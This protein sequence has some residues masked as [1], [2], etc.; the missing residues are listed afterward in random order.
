M[1]TSSMTN[2][3]FFISGG[4]L[5]GDA[6]SYVQRQADTDLFDG[7]K[8]GE[9]C[10]VLTSRQMGK[11]SLM[12]R[13][14]NRLRAD[15]CAVA[16]LDLTAL[17]QN[18]SVN[19]WYFG[20]IEQLGRHL[21]LEDELDD[22]WQSHKSLGPLQR[23]VAA[24]RDVAL[25]R[26]AKPI[27]I[28]VDEIDIVRSLPFST[29][30]FFA[31]IR[32]CYN[33]RAMTPEFER[34]TFCL[35]GVATPSDLIRDTRMTPFNIGRRVELNDFTAAE[36][37]VLAAGLISREDAKTRRNAGEELEKKLLNRVLY[38]TGGHPYLTQKLCQAVSE[39]LNAPTPNDGQGSLARRAADEGRR[40]ANTAPQ[41]LTPAEGQTPPKANTPTPREALTPAEGQTPPKANTNLSP[42]VVNQVCDALFLSARVREQEENLLFVR[43]RLL[44]SDVDTAGLLDLYRTVWAGKKV[45]DEEA[46]GLVDVLR[47]SGIV[48]VMNG[49]LMVR[50][51]IYERVYDRTWVLKH[52]P[53]AELRRQRAA[54]R[55]AALRMA[56]AS[57]SIVMVMAI[58][59]IVAVKQRNKAT[60]LAMTKNKA[61]TELGIVNKNLIEADRQKAALVTSLSGANR[62]KAAA[63]VRANTNLAEA[64]KQRLAALISAN[65]ATRA[66]MLEVG[67]Q[68]V[69]RLQAQV[70][71]TQRD[72]ARRM[73]YIADMN[74]IPASYEHD[75][76]ARIQAILDETR[77]SPYRGFEWG[78][79]DR[80]CHLELLTLAGHSGVVP[81]VAFSP[82]GKRIV[83]GGLD[84]TARVWD[85]TTGRQLVVLKAHRDIIWGVA[86]SP[87]SRRIAT[88]SSDGTVILWD[89]ATGH[90]LLTLDGQRGLVPSVAFSPDGK[91][92][93]SGFWGRYGN[94][95]G[96]IR[97][98]R[99]RHS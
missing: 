42:N 86:F 9:F 20:L 54:G 6:A 5:P 46:S 19:Q 91:R 58:L 33:N 80:L 79:W 63:L 62:Q 53:D 89:S 36:A 87:D 31:A 75:D 66:Q 28:F 17:G 97:G 74:L 55:K 85:A 60:G 48:R 51:R 27:V 11:S 64:N 30:E 29:D 69:S 77:P 84:K 57:A 94:Y 83:A 61:L 43:E 37:G 14:A 98:S 82:D 3:R 12:V 4:T 68:R 81:A 67:A 47:L 65:K 49:F 22:F 96:Y 10:Y 45:A 73:A 40:G 52:M 70:A 93:A 56:S 34:L 92:L 15:G 8:A 41:V 95:L 32:E 1:N 71:R 99:T 44:R 2:D 78:Y 26:S 16:V 72:D 25:V 18:L 23:W 24:I 7:L 88:S 59:I 21:R 35:L 13:T 76:F 39:G 50:N 38:W 90:E